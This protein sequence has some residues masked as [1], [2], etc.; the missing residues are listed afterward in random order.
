M[1]LQAQTL[2][3]GFNKNEY[4]NILNM[5]AHSFVDTGYKKNF[6]FPSSHVLKYNSAEMGLLNQWTLWSNDK[7][8]IIINI[9]GTVQNPVSWLE[10]FYAAM[11]PANGSLKLDTNF[12]FD[13]KLAQDPKASVHIGWL[14]GTAYLQRDILPRIDSAYKKGVRNIILTGHSQGGGITYLM[15]AYLH[16]LQKDKKLPADIRFK[17]YCSAAPKPGNLYFAYDYESY[18]QMG[19]AYNVVNESDWVPEVPFSIQTVTDFNKTNPFT[20]AKTVIEKQSFKTHIA[21]KLIYNK[22]DKPSREAQENFTKYLGKTAASFVKNSLNNYS[23]PSYKNTVHYTRCGNYIV[24]KADEHYFKIFPDS[25]DQIFVHHLH[26]PYLY[27][28]K[29]LNWNDESSIYS[30]WELISINDKLIN[31][32]YPNIISINK[33]GVSGQIACNSFN[34]SCVLNEDSVSNKKPAVSTM[35][36]CEENKM[37]TDQ[38]FFKALE[39]TTNYKLQND[40]LY[41]YKDDKLLILMKKK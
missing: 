2:K 17:T 41:F 11:V 36:M 3:P 28:T 30:N 40:L 10:N 35:K 15:T 1:N 32:E 34:M 22:L 19:W 18:T 8:Q 26:M 12:T 9:R 39:L 23:E 4:I 6:D 31:P 14:I 7:D 13:Y 24:L 5:M 21:M 29:K 27:L 16:Y 37:K 25:K 20:D 33:A 38:E